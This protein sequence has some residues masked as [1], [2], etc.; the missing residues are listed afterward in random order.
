MLSSQT[1]QQTW[2]ASA[3]V[4][5]VP[6]QKFE[7]FSFDRLSF[8]NMHNSWLQPSLLHTFPSHS[9][10]P[11]CS[12]PPVEHTGVE[13]GVTLISSPVAGFVCSVHESDLDGTATPPIQ[14]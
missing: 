2:K 8:F 3:S 11:G 12:S 5:I 13:S 10:A 4:R 14:L 7:K 9:T 1:P 6:I